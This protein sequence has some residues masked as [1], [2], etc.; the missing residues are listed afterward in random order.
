MPEGND[1][2]RQMMNKLQQA[3]SGTQATS[4]AQPAAS[5][6]A[7][8]VTS[9]VAL[10]LNSALANHPVF[11][12]GMPR[13]ARVEAYRLALRTG[14][15]ELEGLADG[16]ATAS[17]VSRT[18][19]WIQ[20][21][22]EA[23]ERHR[24]TSVFQLR[25]QEV[26]DLIDSNRSAVVD[27]ASLPDV[28]QLLATD[29]EEESSSKAHWPCSVDFHILFGPLGNLDGRPQRPL[30]VRNAT[31]EF[32][33][34]AH[35]VEQNAFDVSSWRSLLKMILDMPV[36][37]C[38]SSWE[39]ACF[40]FPTCG[41][42]ISAY[43]QREI[44][45]LEG[46]ATFVDTDDAHVAKEQFAG[47]LRVLNIF[48][49]HLPLCSSSALWLQFFTFAYR[50]V[51]C[52]DT[53]LDSLFRH[54]LE[55]SAGPCVDST[56]LW[57]E[58]IRWRS[59][60]IQ[61]S[62]E[63]HQ[64]VRRMYLR[65]LVLPID[66]L[67]RL[68]AAFDAIE[69]KDVYGNQKKQDDEMEVRMAGAKQSGEERRRMFE[70]ILRTKFLSE[71]EEQFRLA[72]MDDEAD[73]FN[74][75]FL[76]SPF[77]A[78]APRRQQGHLLVDE[79][80][81]SQQST[82]FL[83]W[84]DIIS[85][86]TDI[87]MS[88]S[89]LEKAHAQRVQFF[90]RMRCHYFP[91]VVTTWLDA[92]HHAATC[93]PHETLKERVE[94]VR[95]IYDTA[96]LFHPNSPLLTCA[97]AEFLMRERVDDNRAAS[98]VLSAFAKRLVKEATDDA[99]G[100]AV[101]ALVV[102]YV[103]WLRWTRS[104]SESSTAPYL[105]RL[106][107]KHAVVDTGLLHVIMTS[108]KR[109]VKEQPATFTP[110]R[111]F[112]AFNVFCSEWLRVEMLSL[113]DPNTAVSILRSWSSHLTRM[114]QTTQSQ[115]WTPRMCGLDELV[116]AS[117]RLVCTS[118]P[119]S[120]P[121]VL[122]VLN[123]LVEAFGPL[124]TI[125]QALIVEFAWIRQLVNMADPGRALCTAGNLRCLLELVDAP[126]S[127]EDLVAEW[128]GGVRLL[129]N[130]V[131]DQ[132]SR[133]LPLVAS[134]NSQSDFSRSVLQCSLVPHSSVLSFAESKHRLPNAADSLGSQQDSLV[135]PLVS[136]WPRLPSAV[137]AP[138]T[139]S[140]GKVAAAAPREVADEVMD[141][142]IDPAAAA[143]VL[144]TAAR[145]KKPL[146]RLTKGCVAIA[147]N[148]S[149]QSIRHAVDKMLLEHL[150]EAALREGVEERA[151]KRIRVEGGTVSPPP[152]QVG[153]TCEARVAAAKQLGLMVRREYVGNEQ[154]GPLGR[155]G[156][157]LRG[158]PIEL[159]LAPLLAPPG[160]GETVSPGSGLDVSV[161]F[162]V[163]ALRGISSMARN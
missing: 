99:T 9:A 157:I 98:T 113:R 72:A 70:P 106:V 126:E 109:F 97:H 107:A 153:A 4:A 41:A 162:L 26:T 45:L 152:A 76:P 84:K 38:R 139:G 59:S 63:R 105:C 3:V 108:A 32:I 64:W 132:R 116:V 128:V 93:F 47:R 125:R 130:A 160:S 119:P 71:T 146:E 18:T 114:V 89:R 79:D 83:R 7:R 111:H 150:R 42:L 155:V 102:L 94:R 101:E 66:E 10:V 24:L 16:T 21:Q 74:E 69:G 28:S 14:L 61:N 78:H 23:L 122:D 6:R 49:R 131:L 140:R 104:Y 11:R 52:L 148:K 67:A 73:A 90:L 39:Q 15:A 40:L 19:N 127:S 29:G 43:A 25:D 2:L 129:G 44:D 35:R 51:E 62:V 87:N 81:A 135:T 120:A 154:H 17:D 68:R 124:A 112:R 133:T 142:D 86:E 46:N 145:R 77:V 5:R 27:D 156:R 60:K 134:D 55:K 100:R 117:C 121:A 96:T 103:N 36:T 57:T 80:V 34:H 158:L 91:H 85:S 136:F 22:A 147:S 151:K 141:N 82:L 118:H 159:E 58:Y 54:A 161:P 13:R 31:D 37:Q 115:K 92:A 33:N 53:S 65:V 143:A 56:D 48:A 144:E 30:T 110:T 88:G 163:E 138:T 95:D 75:P 1:L 20:H 137:V 8:R 123:T 12:L 149:R 50:F